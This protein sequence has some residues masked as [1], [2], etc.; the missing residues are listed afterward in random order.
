MPDLALLVQ[1]GGHG[2]LFIELKVR[3]GKLSKAQR[4]MH[5]RLRMAGYQVAV[6]W[7]S[8]EE[9]MRVIEEYLRP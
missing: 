1:R 6:V 7:D 5:H 2:G 4:D 8:V 9:V 3:N